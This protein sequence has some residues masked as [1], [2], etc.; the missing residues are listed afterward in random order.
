MHRTFRRLA[1]A[2]ALIGMSM[3]SMPARA[4]EIT[5]EIQALGK[6]Q[7]SDCN[8][9]NTYVVLWATNNM[10]PPTGYTRNV[11]QPTFVLTAAAQTC[12]A[13]GYAPVGGIT[14]QPG[15]AFTYY[16]VMAK[17]AK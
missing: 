3:A 9:Q 11:A 16:Q 6:L 12:I 1:L 10:A 14:L 4:A 15:D 5:P 8:G 17:V 7:A 2:G 13:A